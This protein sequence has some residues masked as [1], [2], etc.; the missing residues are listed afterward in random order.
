MTM[1]A[2]SLT[3]RRLRR[4]AW[5]AGLAAA[6]A[7]LAFPPAPHHLVYGL[8]RDEQGNPLSG[9]RAEV[10]LEA[11]G[12]PLARTPVAISAEPGVNYRLAIPLDSGVT[13]DLYAPT[14]LRPTVPFRMRVKVGSTVYLPIEMTG[15][16]SLLTR[17]TESTRVDLTLGVDSDGDGLPDA[18]EQ[19]LI[20][21]AG[22]GRS[23]ADIRPDGDDDGD[24]LTNLQ[25]YL[26]GTYAFDPLDGF[27][28]TIVG[29]VEGRS[30]LE[31]TAIR[32]RSYTIEASSDL[33]TWTPIPFRLTADAAAEP[34][35][36]DYRAADTRPLRA[37]V[38]PFAEDN[39]D[40]PAPRFFRLK[41]R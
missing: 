40:E 15:V 31:F 32:G 24:G 21:A 19:A 26:A 25:E 12:G 27:E 37:L 6:G 30:A 38:G 29:T 35:R 7:A 4:L 11:G 14:A 41:A 36:V 13:A 20:A 22:G 34:G 23:L 39:Q 28:L 9:V 10:L 33:A 18:W 1:N 16:A 2:A 17:P 5:F 3:P 8:V